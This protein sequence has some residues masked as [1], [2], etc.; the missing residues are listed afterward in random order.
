MK[1]PEAEEERP[2]AWMAIL[3][4]TPVYAADEQEV[5]VIADVLGAEDIFHGIVVRSGPEAKDVMVPADE[6]RVITNRR[7]V[8]SLTPEEIRALPPYR[9]EESYGLGFVGLLRQRLGWVSE[10]D[11]ADRGTR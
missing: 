1:V 2:L 7:I 5:G 6:V 10:S 9:E 4:D 3:A 11:E 8:T